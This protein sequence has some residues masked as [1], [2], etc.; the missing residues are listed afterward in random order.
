MHKPNWN[1]V[2]KVLSQRQA[3]WHK[4]GDRGEAIYYSP[5]TKRYIK[6]AKHHDGSYDVTEHAT[7]PCG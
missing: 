7:C 3:R 2:A 6:L 4:W 1:E 5:T